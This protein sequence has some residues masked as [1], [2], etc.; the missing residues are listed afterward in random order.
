MG[1]RR[2]RFIQPEIL[3]DQTPERAAPSLADIV[4]INRLLGGHEVLRKCLGSIVVPGE[5]FS[6]LDV[7]AGSGE[8]P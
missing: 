8:R 6:F 4:R 7:G 2:S 1:F 3:D 5:R